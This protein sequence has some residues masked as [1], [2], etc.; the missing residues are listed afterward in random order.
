MSDDKIIARQTEEII[1]KYKNKFGWDTFT[2]NPSLPWSFEFVDKYADRWDV[3]KISQ[4]IWGKLFDTHINDELILDVLDSKRSRIFTE[5]THFSNIIINKNNNSGTWKR[6]KKIRVNS[7]RILAC[8]PNFK[9][10]TA[11][12][13]LTVPKGSYPIDLYV[14]KSRNAL[15]VIWFK[16]KK[17]SEIKKWER[18]AMTDGRYSFDVDY[19]TASISDANG[20]ITTSYSS[21][22]GDG[23]Y[24]SYWGLTE[25]E[26]IICLVCDF[27][28]IDE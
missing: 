16:E 6:L 27:N 2:R 19:A 24:Y 10:S 26:E 15:A 14:L 7:G 13:M 1:D 25:D 22:M 8:D 20:R 3:E 9:K 4:E 17:H 21:G 23:S 5:S 28:I 18:A 12:Y 11:P